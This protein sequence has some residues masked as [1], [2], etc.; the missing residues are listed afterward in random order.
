M[1][2]PLRLQPIGV[3]PG[4]ARSNSVINALIEELPEPGT[5]WPAAQREAWLELMRTAFTL[6]YGEAAG[7]PAAPRK[8]ARPAPGKPS[9]AKPARAKPAKMHIDPGFHIDL[10]G[11]ARDHKGNRILPDDL[12]GPIYDMRGEAGDLGAIRWADETTGIKGLQ[13]DITVSPA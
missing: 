2:S 1:A 6:A 10:D 3:Q 7:A 11:Y 13:L 9:K 12:N 8:P 5:D 4:S